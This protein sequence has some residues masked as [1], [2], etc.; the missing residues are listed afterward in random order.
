[1]GAVLAPVLREGELFAD[2]YEV[3]GVLGTGGMA[4]VYRVRDRQ[5]G[6]VVALKILTQALNAADAER[7]RREVRLARRITPTGPMNAEPGTRVRC[8]TR[9]SP[10]VMVNTCG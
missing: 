8:C 2:R 5:L 9:G 6:D 10:G 7:F 3:E 1:M 4:V